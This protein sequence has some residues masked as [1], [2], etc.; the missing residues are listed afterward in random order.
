MREEHKQRF[1]ENWQAVREQH[2]ELWEQTCA[3]ME[4]DLMS[5]V[6]KGQS[7]MFR[8]I[9]VAFEARKRGQNDVADLI[10]ALG[11]KFSTASELRT[12]TLIP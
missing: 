11:W 3:E 12:T 6:D 8:A 2:G 1:Q 5:G 9:L 4:E 7:V 10:L